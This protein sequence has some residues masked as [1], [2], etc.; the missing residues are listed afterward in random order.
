MVKHF[1]KMDLP[2]VSRCS[3]F[4]SVPFYKRLSPSVRDSPSIRDSLI[5]YSLFPLI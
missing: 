1:D 2:R 4:F 5:V 3:F